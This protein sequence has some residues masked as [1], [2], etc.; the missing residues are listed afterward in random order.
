MLG[1]SYEQMITH[2]RFHS[3]MKILN[4]TYQYST[5]LFSRYEF[6]VINSS[7]KQMLD[8]AKFNK[9]DSEL[10]K[11]I[12]QMHG[13]LK[14][15][16]HNEN[17]ISLSR[18]SFP[19]FELMEE[20]MKIQLTYQELLDILNF[21]NTISKYINDLEFY[22]RVEASKAEVTALYDFIGTDVIQAIQHNRVENIL[23]KKYDDISSTININ[24][25][26]LIL[27]ISKPQTRKECRLE[28]KSYLVVFMISNQTNKMSQ[29]FG[30]IQICIYD[31]SNES[32]FHL[33][34]KFEP[35]RYSTLLNHYALKVHRLL[36]GLKAPVNSFQY[37]VSPILI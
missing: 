37:E 18:E 3:K 27:D 8:L 10:G 36:K 29:I 30:K 14:N 32:D 13:S 33:K 23:A 19:L 20:G 25:D 21:K 16:I 7:L 4:S 11:R 34:S 1:N 9:I 2:Q 17:E 5:L 24:R 26:N 12:F 15:L 35:I 22:I 31:N 6:T 28:F